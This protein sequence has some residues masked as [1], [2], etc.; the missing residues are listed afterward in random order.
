M[1]WG[2]KIPDDHTTLYGIPERE[3][4]LALKT[5][6][7]RDPY[8]LF[9]SNHLHAPE[10]AGALYGSI[11][12]VMALNKATATSMLWVNSAR[13]LVDIDRDDQGV[14]VTFSSEANVIELFMFASGVATD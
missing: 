5:T 3:E 12:Y 10:D 13:T 11:P 4:T 8:Q 2:F 9:A 14:E 7:G 6:T 1:S